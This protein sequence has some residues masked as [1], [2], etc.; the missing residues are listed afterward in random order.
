NDF[1][2]CGS[3]ATAKEKGILLVE[4]RDYTVQDGDVIHFKFA[5]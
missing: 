3:F 2:E 1:L 5:L 4:G